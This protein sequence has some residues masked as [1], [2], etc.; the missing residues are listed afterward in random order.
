[1]VKIKNEKGGD[2][3]EK[4]TSYFGGFCSSL[5][6]KSASNII[7]IPGNSNLNF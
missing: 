3:P 4:K 1:M 6:V 5:R 7:K 2:D